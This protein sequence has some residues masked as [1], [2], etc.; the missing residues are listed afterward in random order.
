MKV[1]ETI[2]KDVWLVRYVAYRVLNVK[3]KTTRQAAIKFCI[4]HDLNLSIT[5]RLQ[6]KTDYYFCATDKVLNI[7]RDLI[8]SRNNEKI[9]V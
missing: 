2:Q 7:T 3:A 9:L 6:N 8:V 5:K 4:Y 1:K